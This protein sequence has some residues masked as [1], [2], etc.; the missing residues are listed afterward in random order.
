MV[1]AGDALFAKVGVPSI[2]FSRWTK[3]VAHSS[4]TFSL[5]ILH[6]L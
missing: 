4:H 6:D 5:K 1:F 2:L 3:E